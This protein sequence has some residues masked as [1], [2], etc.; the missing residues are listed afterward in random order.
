MV[1]GF[2]T[3]FRSSLFSHC[4]SLMVRDRAVTV[5][6]TECNNTVTSWLLLLLQQLLLLLKDP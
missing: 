4:K 1:I 3:E 5:G 6:Q 2:R